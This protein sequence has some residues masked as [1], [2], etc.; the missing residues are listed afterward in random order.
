MVHIEL[1]RIYN[2]NCIKGMKNLIREGYSKYFEFIEIDPPYNISKDEWDK[3]KSRGEYLNF[4]KEVI[5][6]SNQLMSD[7]G[8]L[9]LWHNDILVLSDFIQLIKNNTDLKLKQQC[10]WNKYYK[11]NN[12]GTINNQYGFLN[13]FIQ[14]NMNRNYQKMCE[15]VLYYTKQNEELTMYNSKDPFKIIKEYFYKA[16]KKA[17]LS[18]TKINQLLGHRQAEHTFYTKSQWMFPT[19]DTYKELKTILDLPI[20]Y[21]KLLKRY[22]NMRYTYNSNKNNYRSCIWNY[23]MSKK[24][25]HKTEKPLQLY[26]DMFEV[27]TRKDSKCLFPFT[28]SANNIISL[29]NLNNNDKGNRQYIGFETDKKWYELGNKRISKYTNEV[30]CTLKEVM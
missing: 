22:E 15:Y 17:G 25:K 9:F 26:Y 8:T 27:H 18:T 3:F 14:S 1:N 24:T 13:G 5:N 29:L 30:Q 19:E 20:D 2:I 16:Q 28:G 11:Y 7:N 4:I 6:L 21:N 23:P 10:I 12:D